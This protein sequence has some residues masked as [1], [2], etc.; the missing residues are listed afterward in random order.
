MNNTFGMLSQ[1]GGLKSIITANLYVPQERD[2]GERGYS[3]M[4]PNPNDDYGFTIA[5]KISKYLRGLKASLWYGEFV[6]PDYGVDWNTLYGFFRPMAGA[7]QAPGGSI[8]IALLVFKEARS[9]TGPFGMKENANNR[10]SREALDI[11]DNAIQVCLKTSLFS[12]QICSANCPRLPKKYLPVRKSRSQ[13]KLQRSRVMPAE[14]EDGGR[15]SEWLAQGS[16]TWRSN[17]SQHW[18]FSMHN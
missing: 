16:T 13:F 4:L 6:A 15:K 3:D 18:N 14:L 10:S 17:D 5:V 12:S 1:V 7:Y 8:D 2:S 9:R 11:L